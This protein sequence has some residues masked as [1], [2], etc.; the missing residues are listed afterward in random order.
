MKRTTVLLAVAALCLG[1]ASGCSTARNTWKDTKKLYKEYVDTDPTIDLTDEGITDPAL[2][3]LARLF[4]P[5]DQRLEMFIRVYYTQDNP[6]EAEWCEQLLRDF[7][8]LSGVAV[9]N[10][11]GSIRMQQPLIA[12]RP[13]EFG[14]ILDNENRYTKRGLAATASVDDMGPIIYVGAPFFENNEYAGAIVSWFEPRNIVEA[15]PAPDELIMLQPEAVLWP[16]ASSGEGAGQGFLS[17]NWAEVLK[18]EVQGEIQA[19]GGRYVWQSRY[20][21]QMPILYLTQ[22]PAGNEAKAEKAAAAETG[23]AAEASITEAPPA[24]AGVGQELPPE[25]VTPPPSF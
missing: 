23:Q 7:P 14:P 18:T 24:D 10:K 21:G 13:L 8:W 25:T 3:K 12:M 16:A 6:P 5:V 22:A 2:Q 17:A 1:L 11:D 15:S 19:G 4:G 20:I 9:V